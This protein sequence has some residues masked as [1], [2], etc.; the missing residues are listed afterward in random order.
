MKGQSLKVCTIIVATI[1]LVAF[2][3]IANLSAVPPSDVCIEPSAKKRIDE[4]PKGAKKFGTSKKASAPASVF[5]A[6]KADKAKVDLSRFE[7][8]AG[9]PGIENIGATAMK[10]MRVKQ[11]KADDLLRKELSLTKKLIKNMNQNDP[12][13]P[14]AF[15]RIAELNFELQQNYGFKAMALEEK[16]FQ[17]KQAGKKKKF[18]ELKKKQKAMLKKSEEFRMAAIKAYA[19][20]V[21]VFPDFDRMDEALFY[22]GYSLDEIARM[23][24]DKKIEYAKKAREIYKKLIKEF[25]GSK[26]IPN[27][28]LSFAEFYFSEGDMGNSLKFFKEVTK[29]EDT[30]IYGF[31]LYKQA[32][33][34]YNMQDYKATIQKFI[35]VIEFAQQ[36]P[37][38]P[39]AASLRK[40]S[41]MELVM[42]YAQIGT[43]D[44]AWEFFQKY[45]GDLAQKQMQSLA[46]NYFGQGM[47]KEAIATY[48][49]LMEIAPNND[50]I[51][52]WQYWVTFA[53]NSL[54]NKSSQFKELGRLAAMYKMYDEASH[55]GELKMEC[56]KK[57]TSMIMEQ[58]I[59]WHR[60]AVGTDTQPGTNDPQTM[61]LASDTYNLIVKEFPNLDQL[62]QEG[63]AS[64]RV[65]LYKIAYY[66]AE[67][68]WKMEDW[69]KCGPA[70]DSVVD[71]DPDGE[72]LTD[73]AYASVLCYNNLYHMYHKDDKAGKYDVKDYGAKKGKGKKG[74][75]KKK[76]GKDVD[77]LAG[78]MKEYEPKKIS[79]TEKKMLEAFSRYTCFVE[80]SSDLPSIKYRKCRIYY[81]ANHFEEAAYCFKGVAHSHPNSEVGIFAANLYL[82]ALSAVRSWNDLLVQQ[83]NKKPEGQR[84]DAYIQQLTNKKLDCGA[85]LTNAVDE[86]IKE[87]K[88]K[89]YLEDP[90]FADI[91]YTVKCNI[92][93][94][95]AEDFHA[96]KQFKEAAL[97]YYSLYKKW[98]HKCTNTK[99]DEVLYNMAIEFEAARLIGAAIKA[100]MIL[101][102]AEQYK[103]SEWAK[104]ALYFIGQNYHAIALYEKAAEFYES[105]A[106]KYSGEKEAPEALQN[107]TFFR[108]G[109]GQDPKAIENALLFQKNYSKGK[110]KRPAEVAM[111]FFG[112]GTI[113]KKNKQWGKVIDHYRKYIKKYKSPAA[114]DF[115]IRANMEIADAYWKMKKYDQAQKHCLEVNKLY[116]KDPMAKIQWVG[117]KPEEKEADKAVRGRA[118]FTAVANARFYLGEIYYKKFKLVK[119]PQF[120]PDKMTTKQI[121][122]S[123]DPKQA[124]TE[125]G[126]VKNKY[127]HQSKK[128]WE[129]YVN[130]M[131]FQTWTKKDL[132][133]W[134]QKKDEAM[135]KADAFF[136]EVV[137]IGI[138][139][140]EIA[141]AARHGDMYKEFFLAL[142]DAPVPDII[143]E[144]PKMLDAYNDERDRMAL[145]Y[146]GEAV[147]GFEH[148]LEKAKEK[149][150]FNEWSQLCENELNKLDPNKYPISAEIRTKATLPFLVTAQ[151]K[152]VE[153]ILTA[154]ERKEKKIEVGAGLES[155]AGSA[156]DKGSKKG[157]GK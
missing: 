23:F 74:K 108:L 69:V 9:G 156:G 135:K 24:S 34:L 113:H 28:Y 146:K 121:V 51:C 12:K 136:A 25:P 82:D 116:D 36:H 42:P 123:E 59:Y 57:T 114:M 134:Q 66:K 21:S 95:R 13:K 45:G 27:A 98:G 52:D 110:L 35:D 92:E 72:Y 43:P 20:L 97:T 46:E 40:Q 112:I 147:V 38:D 91:V 100:R 79:S 127:Y 17:A 19:Q 58:A 14:D 30:N 26:Y 55:P 29:Y 56:L 62:P 39:N 15:F 107:A 33:C 139:Q 102:T 122:Y 129:K 131:K 152:L 18:I 75:K 120:K 84:N 153:K 143:K 11:A 101:I 67:L 94:L 37:E 89:A 49:K 5:R 1:L 138:E 22:L 124:E 7:K 117:E 125:K 149:R 83:E 87:P 54:K 61:K 86:F 48:H 132:I 104:R 78:K 111:V 140:W 148:C 44:H 68:L 103:N 130:W 128:D 77:E 126:L 81:E 53:T 70:F 47:W 119:F 115:Q 88:F 76:K 90:E 65:T 41:R 142:Y 145:A 3:R 105:Y 80:K 99:L 137:K 133:E 150:W 2:F 154:A 109:L 31:A 118:M 157:K 85:T 73:A 155:T 141:A 6:Q 4:C 10:Q 50:M 151:P 16:I 93:R 63:D 106:K 64:Q 71:M 8:E 96:N 60:E 144:D 32:W